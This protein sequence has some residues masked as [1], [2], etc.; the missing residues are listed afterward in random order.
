[1]RSDLGEIGIGGLDRIDECFLDTPTI[2]VGIRQS[3]KRGSAHNGRLGRISTA[4]TSGPQMP[5]GDV[6]HACFS[7][8]RTPEGAPTHL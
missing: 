7:L 4:T 1:M 3:E 2:D 5:R 6:W 8:L